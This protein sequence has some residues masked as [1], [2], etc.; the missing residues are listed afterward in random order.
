MGP[1]EHITTAF[2]EWPQPLQAVAKIQRGHTEIQAV[3]PLPARDRA[4][5]V[6][7]EFTL[8]DKGRRAG[9]GL[10]ASLQH[11]AEH[12]GVTQLPTAGVMAIAPFQ[13]QTARPLAGDILQLRPHGPDGAAVVTLDALAKARRATGQTLLEDS[14]GAQ[15]A[16]AIADT[17]VVIVQRHGGAGTRA[18]QQASTTKQSLLGLKRR[19]AAAEL[20]GFVAALIKAAVR[21]HTLVDTAL[22]LFGAQGTKENPLLIDD[23]LAVLREEITRHNAEPGRRTPVCQGRSYREVFDASY[24]AHSDRIPRP[25]EEQVRRCLLAAERVRSN[26]ESGAVALG[27]GP[28]GPNLYW[29][30][31]L[32]RHAGRQLMV[33]FDP[34]DLHQQIHVYSLDGRYL[35]AAECTWRAGF[36]DTGAGRAYARWRKRHTKATRDAAEAHRRMRSAAAA[37]LLARAPADPGPPD[38][39]VRRGQFGVVARGRTAAPEVRPDGDA[40]DLYED[41]FGS[42]VSAALAAQPPKP[43]MD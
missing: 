31:E 36:S 1:G 8:T 17:D 19:V 34:D 38:T 11:M 32:A 26:S 14:R 41:R 35:C 21:R 20:G 4:E 15:R 12:Q 2:L 37:G 39:P 3:A 23:F 22:N 9:K 43:R 29:A 25:T 16:N 7:I 27:Q 5:I 42:V 10:Q 33:R 6:G 40:D 28:H 18:P 30:K 13:I 24:A